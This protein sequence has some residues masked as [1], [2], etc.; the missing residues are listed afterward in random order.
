VSPRQSLGD[1][2][3]SRRHD[4]HPNQSS[5]FTKGL[6]SVLI[7]AFESVSGHFIDPN[8]SFFE[9]L[10]GITASEASIPVGNK[11]ITIAAQV[12]NEKF[13][14]EVLERYLETGENERVDW[15]EIRQ[16]T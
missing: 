9:T 12:A 15:G 8:T 2:L 5:E 1:T 7:E 3:Y 13:Y 4:V 11:W 10:S 16:A 14:M 6:L